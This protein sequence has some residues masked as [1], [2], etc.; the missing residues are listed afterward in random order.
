[1]PGAG[2]FPLSEFLAALPAAQR[3]QQALASARELVGT[4]GAASTVKDQ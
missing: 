3:I 4:P 1:M 2:V